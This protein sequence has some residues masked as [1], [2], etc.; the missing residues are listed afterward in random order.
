M[1]N[2]EKTVAEASIPVDLWNP[3]QVFAF[4]GFVEAADVLLGGAE[5]VFDWSD[6]VATRFALRAHGDD[7]PVTAVLAFLDEAD[8]IAEA[9]CQSRT[10]R[11]WLTSWGPV[12]QL[13]AG[14]AYPSPDPDSPATL[15]AVLS[16][17]SRQLRLEHWGDATQ[18]DNVKFWAGSRG[19][20]GS[21]LARDAVKLVH[22]CCVAAAADPFA[23]A[24]P[25][26]SSFR[27]DWR[28]DYIPIDAGF[29]LNAHDGRI[30]TL[31]YPIV[32]LLAALGLTH[33]RPERL[34]KLDYRYGVS[35]RDAQI[36]DLWLPPS[37]LRAALGGGLPAFPSRRF[38]M[39]LG[40]PAK[41]DQGP[42]AITTVIEERNL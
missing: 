14:A 30:A 16:V 42:R 23:V 11:E 6:A 3:G 40:W 33:A 10:Q 34:T 19:Y 36:G 13:S 32:E 20:P 4:L 18:R 39:E 25:Q 28:R 2:K 22:G 31:G 38:R 35:G 17:G 7:N 8:V 24:E 15:R 9:P 37:L 41:K 27:L 21:A 12:R 26:S 29:S 1:T 5:G